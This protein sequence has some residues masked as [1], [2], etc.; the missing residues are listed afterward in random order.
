MD[1]KKIFVVTQILIVGLLLLSVVPFVSSEDPETNPNG[2]NF[3][4]L[5]FQGDRF[6]NYFG[7]WLNVVI[8]T[9]FAAD[10]FIYEAKP[11]KPSENEQRCQ[12]CNDEEEFRYGCTEYECRSLGNTCELI[13]NEEYPAVCISSEGGH[14]APE[15][16]AREDVLEEEY[17]YDPF[18]VISPSEEHGVKIAYTGSG[19]GTEG[20]IPVYTD[21]ILGINT[22]KPAVCKWSNERLDFYEE[23]EGAM[24]SEGA[25]LK[26][27]ELF[28]PSFIFP[29]P[30]AMNNLG[31]VIDPER[32]Y[33]FYF[34]CEDYYGNSNPVNFIIQ[35]CVQNEPDMTA[36]EIEI[37]PSNPY[38]VQYG[39]TEAY[40]EVHNNE[41][42]DCRWNFFDADFEDMQYDMEGCS[43]VDGEFLRDGTY[44]CKGNLTG[45]E[46]G[47]VT[48]YHVRC[49]DKPWCLPENPECT[50]ITNYES[51]QIIVVGS[52]P[53]VIDEI[54]VNDLQSGA[55]IKDSTQPIEI[56]LKAETSGGVSE[57]GH[58]VCEWST[59]SGSNYYSFYET[60]N[61]V[62]DYFVSSHS[63]PQLQ[64]EEGEHEIFV[65]CH[66]L[67]GNI[68]EEIINFTIE[69]D[70]ESPEVVRVYYEEG[71]LKLITDESSECVYS[72]F[73]G[74][75]YMF[76]EGSYMSS[77]ENSTNHF[78]E[79]TTES[80]I[81]I[82]CRDQY[83]N[84][85]VPVGNNHKCTI[86]V[87][88]SDDY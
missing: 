57:E 63:Q 60:S 78:V 32:E 52:Y 50:R 77:T 87:R 27:H 26:D 28:L 72:L 1:K 40:F 46:S 74:C 67:A 8:N 35:F 22:T 79:W 31:I 18:G 10:L 5:L 3:G 4:D 73:E 30:E 71:N 47:D 37:F 24:T 81:F 70:K 33:S 85:P 51:T 83:G 19:G 20:C 45:I 76:D 62:V 16:Q 80:D 23:M 66:D 15:I 36:P 34:R 65:K 53:L 44:G 55:L 82:K 13:N 6:F 14:A 88:G 29:S 56:E 64:Y 68:A 49:K 69:M 75:E 61:Y 42:A 21:L 84:L 9:N 7:Y 86:I 25:Y 39:L 11:W 54:T 43:Q 12:L 58:A 41:P 2:I 38:Y 17:F 48:D 59:D